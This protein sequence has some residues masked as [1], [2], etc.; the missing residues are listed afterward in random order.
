MITEAFKRTD[1]EL[2]ERIRKDQVKTELRR[3]MVSEQIDKQE[4]AVEAKFRESFASQFSTNPFLPYW[5]ASSIGVAVLLAVFSP[6]ITDFALLTTAPICGAI[7]AL[8][9]WRF[10]NQR[11]RN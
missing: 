2:A 11:E 8:L 7:V 9:Q 6:K 4:L 10:T 5:V 1:R 3:K